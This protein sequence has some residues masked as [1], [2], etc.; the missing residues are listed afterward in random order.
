MSSFPG[1][2]PQEVRAGTWLCHSHLTLGR[3][4]LVREALGSWQVKDAY[5]PE[6][7]LAPAGL[8]ATAT[9]SQVAGVTKQGCCPL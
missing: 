9:T 7:H 8:Q 2:A 5:G 3:T 6:A 4:G 1:W